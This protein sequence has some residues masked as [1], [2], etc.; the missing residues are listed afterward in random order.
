MC[1][2]PRLNY[3]RS[4]NRAMQ[5]LSPASRVLVQIE[6]KLCQQSVA[7]RVNSNVNHGQ[8]SH[9]YNVRE[10]SNKSPSIQK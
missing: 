1:Y 6:Q 9:E 4:R 7:Q 2:A 8:P 5:I 3:L 10:A